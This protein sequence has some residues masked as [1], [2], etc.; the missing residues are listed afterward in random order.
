MNIARLS[1]KRP[2]LITC[3]VLSMLTFGVISLNRLGVDLYP[4]IN[5]P[6]LSISTVYAG[7]APEEIEKLITKPLEEELGAIGG[8]R[9]IYSTNLEGVS[10][11]TIEF[12]LDTDLRQAD[13]NVRGKINI[14]KNK[15]PDDI[16]EPLVQQLD[17]SDAPI[18]RMG[19]VADLTPS[20]LYDIAKEVLKPRL[21]R[22]EGVGDVKILGG[23]RREIQVELD[24]NRLNELRLSTSS[25]VNSMKG[26]GSNIPVGK[27]EHGNTETNFRAIGEYTNFSQIENSLVSFSGDIGSGIA[28]KDLGRVKDGNEDVKNIAYLYYPFEKGAKYKKKKNEPETERTTRYCLFLDV[29]KRSGA[30]TVKVVDEV[31]N[32]LGEVNEML[33]TYKGSPQLITVL[34][35]SHWIRINVEET[36]RDI[37]LGIIL[38]IF[39]VYLFLGNI[40]STL[41]T[42]FAIPNSLI[43]A[44]IIMYAMGFTIN[45]VTLLALSLTVGLLVDDAIVVR[46]NIFRKLEDGLPPEEAAEQGTKEV[47][48]AVIATTLT[49]MSVFIPIAFLQGIVGRF[50]MQFGFTVVFA[51][52]VSLFDALTVAPFLSAYFA[53]SGHKAKN[54]LVT[55]FEKFQEYLEEKY[56]IV[57]NFCLDRSM[58]VIVVTTVIFIGSIGLMAFIKQGFISGG[59]DGMYTVTLKLP[60]GTSLQGTYEVVQKIEERIKNLK[61]LD[62][63]SVTVGGDQGEPEQGKI[64]CFLLPPEM[65]QNDTE[66]NKQETRKY[67]TDFKFAKP[68]VDR[69]KISSLDDKPFILAVKGNNL[70]VIEEYSSRIIKDIEQIKDLTEV[71]SS[72]ETGKP[73][74]QIKMNQTKMKELGVIQGM[75]GMELRY[76]VAGA[77]VGKLSD[78]G[79]EYDIRARLKPE[80][81]DLRYTYTSTKVPNMHNMMVPLTAIAEFSNTN[82]KAKIS[83]QDRAYVIVITANLTPDGAVGTAMTSVHK[84]IKEKYPLPNG[85]TYS[86]I[87]EAESFDE[88]LSGIKVAFILSIIF[89]FLVLASLYESFITPFTILLAIPP[90]MTGAIL[91]LIIS[92]FTLDMFSMIGMIMLMGLV[93]K[94]SILL[95]DFALIGVRAGQERKKAIIDAGVKRL[96]PILMTTFAMMAGMLPLAL[97]LGEGAKIKQSMGIAILGGLIISTIVTLIVVPATFE[98][99]DIFREY[100]ESKFR[101]K[102]VPSTSGENT[103]DDENL[104][105]TEIKPKNKKS[106]IKKS[107]R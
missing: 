25:V 87:G 34:D 22:I 55:S 71:E 44:F 104:P 101:I 16:D 42:G 79:L 106:T 1:I 77:V 28:L 94:N 57:M 5:F 24:Q 20:E 6:M 21:V 62:Y 103:I 35:T 98:Y 51:M 50:F 15:L 14:A 89:I 100:I 86:F 12:T 63:M 59:D 72:Y 49:I 95:V 64:D 75:A 99:I 13:Q 69:I 83:R 2:I 29:Q 39:V 3:I 102:H 107:A 82:G 81:R 41:I 7:A 11:I 27:R 32:R 17:P 4:E 93:T 84:L 56:L 66:W 88:L 33:K 58:I 46:E 60:T 78:N 80:Q 31:N 76:N 65:R 8:I 92:G 61:D 52:A 74:F 54:I 10:I 68:A 30:N 40:R 26:S 47:T 37:I 90:A 36:S 45:I 97:G 70:E 91:A 85:V 38:A 48:L 19:L 9:H 23:T 67:L 105:E 18:L 43:G 73:E 53:G 96:R